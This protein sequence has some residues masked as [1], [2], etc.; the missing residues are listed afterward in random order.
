[1]VRKTFDRNIQLFKFSAYGF[2]KNLRFYEPFLLLFLLENGISYTQIGI[3][4]GVREILINIFEIPSGMMADATG[5]RRT[6]VFSFILFSISFVIFYLSSSFGFFL[7][8]MIV[9]A[10][11]NAFRSG[12]HKAMIFQYLKQKGWQNQKIHYY[13]Y[14]RSWSQIGTAL[15]ALAAGFI[16]FYQD[17]YRIIFLVTVI[18]YILDIF[19]IMSY[20]S[21]LDGDKAKPSWTDIKQKFRLIFR[22]FLITFRSW[23]RITAVLNVSVYSG[24]YKASRDYLQAVIKTLGPLL[25]LLYGFSKQDKI[26]IV[27]GFSYFI[28]YSLSSI[29]SR[30]SGIIADRFRHLTIPLNITLLLGLSMGILAGIGQIS[31][32]PLL[33]II[34]FI[35]IIL[36]ENLRNPMG[37]SYI[38][39]KTQSHVHASVLSAHSQLKSLIAALIAF[40]LGF[41]SDRFGVGNALIIVSSVF[42]ILSPLYAAGYR[43]NK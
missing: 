38:A 16:V 39:S 14:T 25:P 5:R 23:K 15:S 7:L 41:F 40:A 42:L 17:S 1:M 13:G 32:I 8:A 26:S 9:F 34:P 4:Y 2:L 27:V 21:F 18:P 29:A 20:P 33:A 35:L 12:V 3:L 31:E 36:I 43:K 37:V 10:L 11:G 24:F 30:R 6:M 22:D 28:I 19:L